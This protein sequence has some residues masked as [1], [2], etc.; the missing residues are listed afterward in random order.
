MSARGYRFHPAARE[1]LDAAGGRYDERLPGLSLEFF[2][3]VED[4]ISLIVERPD[5]WQQSGTVAGREVRR[6]VMR[7][8]PFAVVYYVVDDIVR[9]VAVAHGRQKPGYWRV[10]TRH[11]F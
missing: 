5:A 10:R 1:E 9:I 6:F 3:A 4:A 7:R 11:E 8:F 2:D